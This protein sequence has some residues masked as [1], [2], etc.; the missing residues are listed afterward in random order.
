MW[1]QS[2]D[3][4]RKLELMLL[5]TPH[6]KLRGETSTNQTVDGELTRIATYQEKGHVATAAEFFDFIRRNH[7]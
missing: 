2:Y 6:P 5:P 3:Y 1:L 7:A 4:S